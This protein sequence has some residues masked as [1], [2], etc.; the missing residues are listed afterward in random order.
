LTEEGTKLFADMT[1]E[2]VGKQIAI[3]IAGRL[4]SAPLVNEPITGGRLLI[5]GDFSTEEAEALARN[6]SPKAAAGDKGANGKLKAP[7]W[8]PPSGLAPS[9]ILDQARADRDAGR[10]EEA[11]AK[12]LWY[13]TAS[14]QQSGQGGVRLS[15]ALGD[16]LKLGQAY[17]PALRALRQARDETESALR[18]GGVD[19]DRFTL[20]MEFAGFNRVLEEDH[21]NGELLNDLAVRDPKFAADVRRF[22]PNLFEADKRASEGGKTEAL[23]QASAAQSESAALEHLR[24]A[25]LLETIAAIESTKGRGELRKVLPILHPD[26]SLN[27]LLDSL[28]STEQSLAGLLTD[29]AEEHPEV[30]RLKSVA[31]TIHRQIDDRMDAILQGLKV[32]LAVAESV[33]EQMK[34]QP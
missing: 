2:H 30:R 29:H 22:A 26:A 27:R 6:L 5:T 25:R 8:E 3:V 11:L 31:A 34:K 24:L 32:R 20:F 14:R 23:P 16:W 9:Q 28:A 7:R 10:H 18:A 13:H 15:F 4:H 33:A 19:V 1:R 21:K 12:H 17:P